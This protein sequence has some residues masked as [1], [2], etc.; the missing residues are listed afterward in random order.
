VRLDAGSRARPLSPSAV[1]LSQG[2]VYVDTGSESGRFEVRTAVATARDIGTQFEVRLLERTLRL[3]VRSGLVELKDDA[4][5]VSARAG[6]EIT[7]SRSGSV[8]RPIA[9]YGPEW[10]W[11]ARISPPL[12]F[13]GMTLAT[14]LEGVGREHGWAIHYADPALARE[15]SGIVLHGSVEGL[16]AREA[17]EA[18]VIT[19]GLRHRFESGA[20]VVLRGASAK[21]AGS[22]DE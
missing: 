22:V 13:E 10:D 2:A 8:G 17:V 19:S 12:T 7:F 1:E 3:R 4:R 18:A 21:Q 20:L 9:A 15:A 16:S 11:T 6:T 5:S 14:F